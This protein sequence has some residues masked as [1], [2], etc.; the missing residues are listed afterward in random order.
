RRDQVDR[1]AREFRSALRRLPGLERQATFGIRSRERLEVGTTHARVG[2]VA[3][4]RNDL[5]DGHATAVV[6]ASARTDQ[7]A[8]TETELSRE[9]RRDPGVAGFVEI[10][11][12]GA[13]DEAGI[14]RR[15]EPSGRLAVD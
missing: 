7:V 4:D 3:V 6:V 8:A 1:A 11:V 10:A 13:A 12:L 2:R 9:M 5:G 14:A 15:I